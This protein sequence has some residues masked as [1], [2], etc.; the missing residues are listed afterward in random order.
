MMNNSVEVR[1]IDQQRAGRILL[2]LLA[3]D[4]DSAVMVL[5]E[6]AT[7]DDGG[8]LTLVLALARFG[9]EAAEAL[10]PDGAEAAIIR[11]L[12]DLSTGK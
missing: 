10:S 12:V 7:D 1:R 5:T 9:V 3:S 6:A 11:A 4:N 2:A 8:V